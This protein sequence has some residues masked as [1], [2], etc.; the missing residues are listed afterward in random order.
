MLCIIGV[1]QEAAIRVIAKIEDAQ[2][3]VEY[4]NRH[5]HLTRTANPEFYDT[6]VFSFSVKTNLICY[7]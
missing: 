1:S 7:P 4:N 5:K 3:K 2:R 6:Q